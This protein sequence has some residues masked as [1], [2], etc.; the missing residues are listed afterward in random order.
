MNEYIIV[1]TPNAHYEIASIYY[2]IKF[3]LLNPIASKEFLKGITTKINNLKLFPYIGSIYK[4]SQNRFIIYKD[5]YI[6]GIFDQREK[7]SIL[8]KYAN[9]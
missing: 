6:V 3:K 4:D 2:Y 5:F 8:D 9:Y 1:R 7:S